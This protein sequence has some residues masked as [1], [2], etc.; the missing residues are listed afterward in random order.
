ML[1]QVPIWH[2]DVRAALDIEMKRRFSVAPM[3]ET[4]D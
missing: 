2:G 1:Y 3:M 4:T